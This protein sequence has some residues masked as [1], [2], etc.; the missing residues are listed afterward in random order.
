M[1]PLSSKIIQLFL[2]YKVLVLICLLGLVLRLYRLPE[3]ASY[4]FDQEY[5]TT[6]VLQ[7]VREYPIRLVGQGLSVQGLFMGPFYFYALVPFYLLFGLDPLGGVVGSVLLGMVTVIAY[8]FVVSKLF[9]RQAGLWAALIRSISTYAMFADWVMV[10]SYGSDVAALAVLYLFFLIW[11]NKTQLASDKIKLHWYLPALLFIFGLFTSFHPI[12]FP[13][14][15]VFIILLIIWKPK[16]NWVD[17]LFGCFAFLIPIAPILLFDYFRKWSMIRQILLMFTGTSDFSQSIVLNIRA[18]YILKAINYH[19][20]ELLALSKDS[21]AFGWLT[22]LT[23]ILF[24]FFTI[25]LN[26]RKLFLFHLFVFVLTVLIFYLYYVFFPAPVPEYYLRVT[27]IF[28][29]MY[30]GIFIAGLKRIKFGWLIQLVAVAMLVF[31]NFH[32][33]WQHWQSSDLT[34]LAYKQRV[35]KHI[36]EQANGQPFQVSYVTQP[37]WRSGFASLFELY[38]ARPGETGPIYTI[39]SPLSYLTNEEQLKLEFKT[40]G[41]GVDDPD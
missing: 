31:L 36:I 2:E 4:D 37:G 14:W 32:T 17:W 12:Q 16:F 1:A 19:W 9:S 27:Q 41:L 5:V 13:F 6:F 35:I 24:A 39:V 18:E 15:L 3:M 40:G 7:V 23:C 22:L 30:L 29:T 34:S 25:Y 8:Y 26:Q 11:K 21:Q 33:L 28:M 20:F 38:Q 10:P